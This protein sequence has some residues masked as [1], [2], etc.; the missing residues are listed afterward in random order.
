MIEMDYTMQDIYI[1][2]MVKRKN[3]TAMSAM[4]YLCIFM[5]S[6]NLFF[7]FFSPLAVILVLAFAGLAFFLRR[8]SQIEY[9]YILTNDSLDIEAIY[10]QEKRKRVYSMDLQ[11]A[12]VIAPLSDPALGRAGVKG[13][14]YSSHEA[15][16]D[17]YGIMWK[18][19]K[20]NRDELIV[21]EPNE[22]M[23]EIMARRY[24]HVFKA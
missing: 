24:P 6:V 4:F 20:A 1:E 23:K 17:R 3:I 14:D 21:I 12:S 16:A 8:Y 19:P 13:M 18:N 22:E 2:H 10:H 7:C 11:N 9:E 15:A 5:A